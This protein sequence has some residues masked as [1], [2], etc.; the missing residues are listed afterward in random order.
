MTLD[1]EPKQHLEKIL[2][3]AIESFDGLCARWSEMKPHQ[4]FC[5]DNSELFHMGY[6]F[7]SI[8]EDFISWFYSK[9]GRSMTDDEYNE[10]WTVCRKRIREMHEKF[11]QFYFQE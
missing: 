1:N 8:E 5:I 9:Y 11:D 6:I 7:G 3:L 10:Y 2:D 4:K